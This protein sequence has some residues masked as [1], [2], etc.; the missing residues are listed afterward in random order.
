MISGT[1]NGSEKAFHKELKR[2]FRENTVN[3]SFLVDYGNGVLHPKQIKETKHT[4]F[5]SSYCKYIHEG[6]GSV[7]V[8]Q[9]A[10]E[11]MPFMVSI[12][13]ILNPRELF[14][15]VNEIQTFLLDNLIIT[16]YSDSD[17]DCV[18]L[19]SKNKTFLH[20]PMCRMVWDDIIQKKLPCIAGLDTLQSYKI[21]RV[22]TQSVKIEETVYEYIPLYGSDDLVYVKTYER[23]ELPE[24]E[25]DKAEPL[26]KEDI[27]R[28]DNKFSGG[29]EKLDPAYHSKVEQKLINITLFSTSRIDKDG[30]DINFHWLP[31]ILS[32]SY[33]RTMS[34]EKDKYQ[35]KLYHYLYERE[36]IYDVENMN[37]VS[38]TDS[39]INIIDNFRLFTNMCKPDTLVSQV[40]WKVSGEVLATLFKGDSVG[41]RLWYNTLREKLKLAT[42]KKFLSEGDLY[43]RCEIAYNSFNIGQRD[44]ISMFEIAKKDNPDEAARWHAD[45]L[46]EAGV[47]SIRGTHAA[48]AQVMRRMRFLDTFHIQEEKSSTWFRKCGHKCVPDY[49]QSWLKLK[50][51]E[52]VRLYMHIQCKISEQLAKT[53]MGQI[54]TNVMFKLARIINDLESNGFQESMIKAARS[55]FD[56]ENFVDRSQ[57]LTLLLNG[58]IV[59]DET[60]IYIRDGLLQD[61]LHK[62]FNARY[63][64]DY[65]WDHPLVTKL[66]WWM[67]ITFVN[68]ETIIYF[69]KFLASLLRG[70]N[71][72]KKVYWWVGKT[73][74][75]MKSTWQKAV[76]RMCGKRAISMPVNYFTMG[77]GTANSATPA[78]YGLLGSTVMFSEEPD[79]NAQFLSSI[80]K[81]E[82]CSDPRTGRKNFGDPVDWIPTHK[83]VIVAN[84]PNAVAKKEG[85]LV[86]RM[87]F[88]PF[89][90]QA[91][92]DAPETLEEQI[93]KRI[94]PRD[95]FFDRVLLTLTNALLWITVQSYDI[96]TA[97]GMR[98][99]PSDVTNYTTDY[100]KSIDKYSMFHGQYIVDDEDSYIDPGVWY[101]QFFVWHKAI[102]STDNVPVYNIAFESMC[103]LMGKTEDGVWKGVKLKKLGNDRQG[104]E[105]PARRT[106]RRMDD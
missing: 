72:D 47:N 62:S 79:E 82:G 102:F 22:V 32:M 25:D 21:D 57:E 53:S 19:K 49:G 44:N 31:I 42:N 84:F 60:S 24:Q 36:R 81:K 12:E 9:I 27:T 104:D 7:K 43:E 95:A 68:P 94:F 58:V 106:R 39:S 87:V 6:G 93:E 69:R 16:D 80:L 59:A 50:I 1:Q 61:Y 26:T 74:N 37:K 45:W 86:E 52:M 28:L 77:K 98:N 85:A 78:E 20:F 40:Y 15:V 18:V 55:Y 103:E 51:G 48:L 38:Y 64:Y 105:A 56:V 66:L 8:H 96:Y 63:C 5:W 75:N 88:I 99:P 100:W 13:K 65:S 101:K 97:E 3:A 92:Y 91:S 17:V 73:G 46:M 71:N 14:C 33:W 4:T 76:M 30:E 83:T 41:L 67:F 11:A 54:E 89:I 70:G 2:C 10:I 90:S 23:I 34:S 35:E 29:L